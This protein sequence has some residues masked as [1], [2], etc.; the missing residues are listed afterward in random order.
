ML[1]DDDKRYAIET[2][3]SS[4][5]VLKKWFKNKWHI[6]SAFVGCV[7]ISENL[8][9][10]CLLFKEYSGY[11][12]RD[13]MLTFTEYR[14]LRKTGAVP[15]QEG[16]S[17][18]FKRNSNIDNT[19]LSHK[20][21]DFYSSFSFLYIILV[22]RSLT[23]ALYRHESWSLI[24]REENRMRVQRKTFGHKKE[25]CDKVTKKIM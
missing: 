19:F 6:I 7:I 10:S 23:F 2:C 15:P 14:K 5:S 9:S 18:T 13:L 3:R 16:V 17:F 21:R 1:P 22:F 20:F 24:L 8:V 25:W 11:S 12:C 4:E